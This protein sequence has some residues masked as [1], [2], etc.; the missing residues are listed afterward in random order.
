MNAEQVELEAEIRQRLVILAGHLPESVA[1][2][3]VGARDRG[4]YEALAIREAL[5]WRVEELGRGAFQMFQQDDL[6]SAILLSRGVVECAA[7][8]GRVAHAVAE[9]ANMNT[10]E[11]RDTLTKMLSS[12][13]SEPNSSRGFDVATYLKSLNERINGVERAYEHLSDYAHPDWRKAD[14]LF[15]RI[16][17]EKHVTD[18]G[19]F[20]ER[21]QDARMHALNALAGGLAI[22]EIEYNRLAAIIVAWLPELEPLEPAT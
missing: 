19:R 12:W 8:M 3:A 1:R 6:A 20:E 13:K 14:Q 7:A 18:F 2:L 17:D 21:S 16:D 15:S 4:P 9:R 11:L 22:F 10:T 5:A